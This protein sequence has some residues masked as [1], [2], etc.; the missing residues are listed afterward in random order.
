MRKY[1]YLWAAILFVLSAGSPGNPADDVRIQRTTKVLDEKTLEKLITSAESP[2]LIFRTTTPSLESLSPGDVIVGGVSQR[3]PNGLSPRRIVSIQREGDRIV[4]RTEP[5]T[6]EDVIE[7][8]EINLQQNLKP[9]GR[10][11]KHY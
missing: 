3:A 7:E 8:G 11:E 1:L 5:A 6:L 9:L 4:V 2:V 10:S